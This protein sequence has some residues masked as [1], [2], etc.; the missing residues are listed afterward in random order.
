[1]A[2]AWPLPSNYAQ[3]TRFP[4][5]LTMSETAADL[6]AP[7]QSLELFV[8]GP[9]GRLETQLSAPREAGRG[10]CVVCHPHPLY[11]GAMSNKVVYA[12]AS[13]ALKAGFVTARFNFR[14]VGRSE[15]GY[16]QARG[17]TDDVLAVVAWLRQRLPQAP[18]LLAGFSF[19]AY[20]SLKAAAQA[21]P[22]L[23][24]SASIPFRHYFDDEAL[25]PHPGCPW[26]AVHSADDEVVN[27]EETQQV[28]QSYS[29]PPRL[30]RLEG[31]GHFYHGRLAELQQAVLP[32]LQ[33]Q[34]A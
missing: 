33:E 24:L 22:A 3:L 12:L 7:G 9:A 26:L 10:I 11:G 21:R 18:L 23:Q 31:A 27:F 2:P 1:L 6:P 15:G 16:D 5:F 30:V 28:L 4:L 19:G 13:S 34:A 20:V 25:P 8:A 17:E 29:P 32:F 14:G